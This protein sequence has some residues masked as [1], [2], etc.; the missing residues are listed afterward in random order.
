MEVAK[1]KLMTLLSKIAIRQAMNIKK[2]QNERNSPDE[3]CRGPEDRLRILSSMLDNLEKIAQS[4]RQ[5]ALP[6][7]ASNNSLPFQLIVLLWEMAINEATVIEEY[8]Q[9][10]HDISNT[11]T[12]SCMLFNNLSQIIGMIQ[13]G[14]EKPV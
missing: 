1:E 6:A 10:N 2:Y 8:Q 3:S 12:I 7:S 14:H 4:M 5:T 9:S 13:F 11:L